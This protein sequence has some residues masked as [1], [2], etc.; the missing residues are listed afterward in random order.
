MC[1]RS[2]SISGRLLACPI[3]DGKNLCETMVAEGWA[4]HYRQCS[5]DARLAALRAAGARADAACGAVR[6]RGAVGAP[7]GGT[8][9]GR[10][11][12]GL[13]A[14]PRQRQEPRLSR[15]RLPR[16]QLRELPASSPRARP[17]K[18]PVI[19]PTGSV[20][21]DSPSPC[22]PSP[23]TYNLALTCPFTACRNHARR[24]VS[25]ALRHPAAAS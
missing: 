10:R 20:Y 14:V 23:V 17:P 6:T 16:L 8:R 2:A 7:R 13:P 3:V 21:G 15:R 11:G 12:G 1:I 25:W 24:E 5:S 18:R 22:N 19:D 4:W 9:S